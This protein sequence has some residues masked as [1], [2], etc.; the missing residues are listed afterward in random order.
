M[1]KE[2]LLGRN[3]VGNIVRLAE[4]LQVTIVADRSPQIGFFVTCFRGKALCFKPTQ[5]DSK[6]DSRSGVFFTRLMFLGT[7]E[8]RTAGK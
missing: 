6:E 2:R 4:D 5:S 8:E 3:F 7:T 1:P